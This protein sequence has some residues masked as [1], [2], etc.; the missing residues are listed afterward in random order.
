MRDGALLNLL[1][2]GKFPHANLCTLLEAAAEDENTAHNFFNA[3]DE[4]V[5][6]KVDLCRDLITTGPYGWVF[7]NVSK[8]IR[9]TA[10]EYLLRN[11]QSDTEDILFSLDLI[12]KAMLSKPERPRVEAAYNIKDFDER[13]NGILRKLWTRQLQPPDNVESVNEL[14]IGDRLYTLVSSL[15]NK[16]KSIDIEDHLK[17]N[18]GTFF[19]SLGMPAPTMHFYKPGEANSVL[20]AL[21]PGLN[22]LWRGEVHAYLPPNGDLTPEYICNFCKSLLI[23]N[24]TY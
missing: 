22:R 11:S 17:K 5:Q 14:L 21:T 9:D 15:K 2:D 3:L 6:A 7:Q 19:E 8:N 18:I 23:M 4:F 16:R 1:R 24:R 13:V 12:N 10:I 20:D